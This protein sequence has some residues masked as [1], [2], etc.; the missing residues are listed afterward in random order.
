MELI[1]SIK[2]EWLKTRKSAAAWLCVIG[3]LFIPLIFLIGFIYNKETLAM[4]GEGENVW[5]QHFFQVWQAMVIFLLPM[6]LVLATSLITQMEF[7]NNTWKQL[8]TTPQKYSIIFA[9]KFAVILGMTL[10][11][12]LYFNVGFILS[13][14]I[15]SLL[16][17][18]G[19]PEVA[20][21][22]EQFFESNGKIFIT[23]LPILA[24]QFLISLKF[25]NFLVPIGVGLVL[26]V[27]TL[28]VVGNWEHAY[29]SPYSYGSLTIM[30]SPETL[31][32]INIYWLSV[33][34]FAVFMAASFVLYINK[35]EKG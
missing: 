5:T 23:C 25:K 10:Q 6:G 20:F 34:Y 11:F 8:H 22:F 1:N 35:S 3:G 18:K 19:L 7:R 2:S 17:D 4:Y 14:V 30:G 32:K 12:F 29:L 27:T 21:P 26:L 16:F 13:G 15:P 33:L 28:I 24:L 9:A 31:E